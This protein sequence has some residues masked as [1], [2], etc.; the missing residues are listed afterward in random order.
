MAN[1]PPLYQPLL[2]NA[3]VEKIREVAQPFEAA[4]RSMKSVVA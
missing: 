3:L 4:C 1:L 2:S